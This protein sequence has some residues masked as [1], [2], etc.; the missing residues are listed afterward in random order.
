L[1]S[2]A[3]G[4]A[5]IASPASTPPVPAANLNAM[6]LDAGRHFADYQRLTAEGKLAEAGQKLELLKQTLEQLQQTRQ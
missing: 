6:I 4:L 3:A 5:T 2:T 1:P